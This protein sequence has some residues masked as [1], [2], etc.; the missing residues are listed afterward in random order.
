MRRDVFQAI[1]DPTRREIISIIANQTI[2]P[3]AMADHFDVSRQAISKHIKILTE[4]GLIAIKQEGRERYCEARLDRL[5][6]VYTWVGQYHKYWETKF[7]ALEKYL[8][9]LQKDKKNAG[10]K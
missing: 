9:K 8:D 2:T 5:N 6:E 7:N 4:C 3:T 10:K 1:A